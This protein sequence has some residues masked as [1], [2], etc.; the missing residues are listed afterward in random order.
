M[1]TED[2]RE[3]LLLRFWVSNSVSLIELLMSTPEMEILFYA[4]TTD[5]LGGEIAI[6]MLE[7]VGEIEEIS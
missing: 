1:M 4:Q 7:E 3:Q 5:V 2:T 6:L